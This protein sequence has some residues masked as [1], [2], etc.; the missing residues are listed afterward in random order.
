MIF[1][2]FGFLMTFLK[3]Y[4]YSA[5]SLNFVTSCLVI[6]ESVLAIGWMQQGL[7][8]VEIDLPL[9]IDCAFAAGEGAQRAA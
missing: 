9:L 5:V 6:L 3:R 1:L 7:G 2:G 8:K 4:S